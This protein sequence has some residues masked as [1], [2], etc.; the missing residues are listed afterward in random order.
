MSTSFYVLHFSVN[1]IVPPRHPSRHELKRCKR[2]A[3]KLI[4]QLRHAHLDG[5]TG[6][7]TCQ[8]LL[9]ERDS[10][11]GGDVLCADDMDSV[12]LVHVEETTGGA[13]R[14]KVPMYHDAPTSSVHD[15]RVLVSCKLFG[16]AHDAAE[17][18]DALSR[19][20][21]E[22]PC[23]RVCNFPC[24]GENQ[25]VVLRDVQPDSSTTLILQASDEVWLCKTPPL[26]AQPECAPEDVRRATCVSAGSGACDP[27]L[28]GYLT[29][30]IE[31]SAPAPRV[32]RSVFDKDND[33]VFS[34]DAEAH[35]QCIHT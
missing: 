25:G 17:A 28:P 12:H 27:V 30:A 15:V 9:R 10:V 16:S 19:A 18:A 20:M 13:W 22:E 14:A 35:R 34:L 26:T 11:W 29:D 23:M 5:A 33:D 7:A 24:L 8:P 32:R 31:L 6:I 2:C 1:S 21:C 3:R 4:P